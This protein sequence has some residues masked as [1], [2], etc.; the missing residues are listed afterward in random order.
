MKNNSLNSMLKSNKNIIMQLVI[1]GVISSVCIL[2][3]PI[4]LNFYLSK[5]SDID[6][7]IVMLI[8][9]C[10]V[11]AYVI[12]L[13]IV[14]VKNRFAVSFKVKQSKLLY[15]K[16]FKLTYDKYID[17]QPSYLVER[18]QMCVITLYNLFA[19]GL[20]TIIAN[21]VIISFSLIFC[22]TI[23]KVIFLLLLILL[24][25]NILGYKKL[26]K[27]L[28][29]KASVMQNVVASNFKD[30]LSVVKQVDYI[31]Q[32]ESTDDV[33]NVIS[34]NLYDLEKSMYDVNIYAGAVSS[35]LKFV[36]SLVQNIIIMLCGY[37]VFTGKLHFSSIFI[38]SI[39]LPIYFGSITNIIGMNVSLRDLKG[40]KDFINDDLT[41]NEEN[42]GNVDVNDVEAIKIDI[43]SVRIK[44]NEIISNVHLEAKKG[45]VVGIIGGSGSGKS[46]IMKYILKFRE[47]DRVLVNGI[48][49]KNIRNKSLRNQML[50][51]SQEVPILSKSLKDNLLFGRNEN[52]V[53]FSKLDSCNLL[54]SLKD[55]SGGYDRVILENGNNLSG[56]EKQKIAIGRHLIQDGSVYILDEITSSID[57]KSEQEIMDFIMSHCKEKI[58]FIISHNKDNSK[59]CNKKYKIENKKFLELK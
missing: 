15:D 21:I 6:Y 55:K 17:L 57:K 46:T 38:L 41:H 8:I 33:I 29:E 51:F 30:I 44:D 49:I 7:S 48:D 13:L 28:Q 1:L 32:A 16:V 24:P 26:N 56:G 43:D 14:Y 23:N 2:I 36:N 50:Y 3:S 19:E 54:E 5:G 4:L 40:V 37:L 58:V 22:F 42:E 31:K 52:D 10:M 11:S 39:I 34:Q 27:K 53:D 59:Y 25:F 47:V 12:Q 9:G 18:I 45:D 20:T 35:S